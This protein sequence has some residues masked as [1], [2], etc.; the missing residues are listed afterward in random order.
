MSTIDLDGQKTRGVSSKDKQLP[1]RSSTVE[2]VGPAGAGKSTLLRALTQEDA[3]VV[4]A[5]PIPK[6]VLIPILIRDAF[7]FF[8]TYV[9]HFRHSR[10]FT[11]GE[12][13]AIAYLTG[14]QHALNHNRWQNDA[15]VVLDH[16]PIF[17]LALLREF[18]PEFTRS[19][20]FQEWWEG[21]LRYW[22][23]TLGLVIWLDAPN[24]ILFQ[25]INSRTEKHVVKGQSEEIV[26]RFFER[27]RSV[28]QEI[29]GTMN[30]AYGLKLI[31]VNTEDTCIDVTVA[32][33]KPELLSMLEERR[34]ADLGIKKPEKS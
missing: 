3:T 13:R 2:V 11:L 20:S 16:G 33:I 23:V 8:P 26:Y 27:Y 21:M 10:W 6:K 17:R 24:E 12:M 15:I 28:Y 9:R 31:R 19:D 14:W 30:T 1:P 7:T 4:P 29:I 34:P 32:K 25:R 22:A 18:G 5:I